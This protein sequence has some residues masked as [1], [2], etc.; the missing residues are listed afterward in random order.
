[1]CAEGAYLLPM[2]CS[3][4]RIKQ[5]SSDRFWGDSSHCPHSG[6]MA[7]VRAAIY[8]PAVWRVRP[9]LRQTTSS[10]YTCYL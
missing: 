10:G 8:Y 7:S 5:H 2:R 9:G 6:S 4:P 3:T 1:M